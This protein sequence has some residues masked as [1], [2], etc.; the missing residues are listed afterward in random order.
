[1]LASCILLFGDIS[2]WKMEWF[3]I[4]TGEQKNRHGHDFI[5]DKFR[6]R[7]SSRLQSSVY[8][9]WHIYSRYQTNW[10]HFTY[11]IFGYSI[12]YILKPKCC[13]YFTCKLNSFNF[14]L[15]PFDT[16]S[17]MLVGV[18]AIQAATFSIF[19][20]EWMSPSGFDMKVWFYEVRLF[21][22]LSQLF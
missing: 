15:E 21:E 20:F 22:F 13:E 10:Y 1:M 6:S 14:K 12:I 3:N 8:G 2:E 5:N 16:A 18:V 17:W 19:A 7:I 4:R 9:D 11:S